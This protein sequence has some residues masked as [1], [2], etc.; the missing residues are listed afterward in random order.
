MFFF[1][2]CLR[3]IPVPFFSWNTSISRHGHVT[4]IAHGTV[5][6]L[7]IVLRQPVLFVSFFM[8]E[9]NLTAEQHNQ[10]REDPHRVV[11]HS[12]TVTPLN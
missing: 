3:F 12:T 9:Q 5:I 4:D 2:L 1:F 11:K 8:Q 6:V 7:C 10:M